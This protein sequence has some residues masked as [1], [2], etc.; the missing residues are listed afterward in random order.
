ML[1]SLYALRHKIFFH[2]LGIFLYCRVGVAE[3]HAFI[4][5]FRTQFLIEAFRFVLPDDAGKECPLGLRH[6]DFLKGVFNVGGHFVPTLVPPLFSPLIVGDFIKMQ[7]AQIGAPRR[8]RQTH[9]IFICFQA[10]FPHPHRLIFYGGNF[11]NNLARDSLFR[12][13][14]EPVW[15]SITAAAL[16]MCPYRCNYAHTV[17]FMYSPYPF[18]S[19]SFASASVPDFMIFPLCKMCTLSA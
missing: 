1:R 5:P 18:F 4:L 3:N 13:M 6:A 19:M 7:P 14:N 11:L 9:K 8:N 17:S 10:Q 15:Q 12:S 2:Q 16:L